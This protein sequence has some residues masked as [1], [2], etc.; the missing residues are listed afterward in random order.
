ML[1]GTDVATDGR[2]EEEGGAFKGVST[3]PRCRSSLTLASSALTAA[4]AA[5]GWK[6]REGS[7]SYTD[8]CRVAAA[9]GDRRGE[10]V[11][12]E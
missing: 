4:A 1:G 3:Q 7:W 8:N 11:D 6:E 2:I 5:T 10:M 12:E 9:D